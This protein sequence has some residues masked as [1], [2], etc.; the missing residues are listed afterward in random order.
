M[1]DEP[2]SPDEYPV[3]V[4]LT[5]WG[6]PSRYGA[7]VFVFLCLALGGAGVVIGSWDRRWYLAVFAAPCAV[8]Y[9][10]ALRWVDRHGTWDRS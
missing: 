2:V 3:W 4:K 10:L 9:W 8:P 5:L 7:W 1:D 6:I